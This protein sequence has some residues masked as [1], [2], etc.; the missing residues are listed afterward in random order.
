MPVGRTGFD[1]F[2]ACIVTRFAYHCAPAL[3][4][5]EVKSINNSS[6]DAPNAQDPSRR[7]AR[8]LNAL[9]RLDV[10][11]MR[12]RTFADATGRVYSLTPIEQVARP[13]S[14]VL[15]DLNLRT[16]N[17]SVCAAHKRSGTSAPSVCNSPRV[18]RTITRTPTTQE[19]PSP[20]DALRRGHLSGVIVLQRPSHRRVGRCGILFAREISPSRIGDMSEFATKLTEEEEEEEWA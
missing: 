9:L 10:A 15:R 11:P 19:T 3:R 4:L 2:F 7:C 5:L 20:A 13:L 12:Y 14:L 16:C 17:S 1:T 6:R 8:R 18:R